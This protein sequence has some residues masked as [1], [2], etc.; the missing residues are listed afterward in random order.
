MGGGRPIKPTAEKELMGTARKSRATVA[1]DATLLKKMPKP[2]VD[3]GE[4]AI[5]IWRTVGKFLIEKSLLAEVDLIEFKRY[6]RHA[7]FLEDNAE[8]QFDETTSPQEFYKYIT[9]EKMVISYESLYGLNPKAR[10]SMGIGQ[11]TTKMGVLESIVR[12]EKLG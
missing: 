5:F 8:S 10:K 12:S 7:A 1:M 2:P 11:K 3:F 6:C 4:S 9:S